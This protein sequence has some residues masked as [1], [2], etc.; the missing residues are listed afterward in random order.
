MKNVRCN[1]LWHLFA[2][3]Y[4]EGMEAVDNVACLTIPC[5][6]LIP[7]NCLTNNQPRGSAAAGYKF[8]IKY[9][10]VAS[11]TVNNTWQ[12]TVCFSSVVDTS[13][14][15]NIPILIQL[16]TDDFAKKIVS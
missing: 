16:T 7:R 3:I 8:T 5:V 4:T 2:L 10:T 9:I 15:Y 14:A 11:H 1:K 12:H 13:S 6:L